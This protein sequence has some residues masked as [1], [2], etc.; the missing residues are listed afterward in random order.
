[1]KISLLAA[2]LAAAVATPCARA[3]ED[4]PETRDAAAT[5]LDAVSVI[6]AGQARQVQRIVPQQLDVLPPGT[7]L[8]KALNLLPGVNAQSADALGSN[9]QSMTMSLRGFNTTR[10]GYTLDGIPL[11]DGAYNNY[12][13]LSI[14]RALISENMGGAELAVGIGNLSTPS[15]SNLGGTVSY[16]SAD[17][18]TQFGGRFTQTFGS[19]GNRRSFLRVDS[20]E[21]GGFSGYVS[22]MDA[23][24]DL[25]NDQRAY[26]ASTT[27][28]FN[29]KGVYQDE[30][31]RLSAFVDTSRT[32]QADYF[33]LSKSEMARGL[34]WDWG[35]YAPDWDKAV[36]KAYCNASTYSAARCDRSDAALDAD[37]GFTGG[38]I[39]RD[40]NLY[41]LSADLFLS[42]A[43]TLHALGYRHSDD[44][45]GHNW[46]SG[47]WSNKGTAQE[48]PIIFRNTLYTID[49]NG[50][51]LGLDWDLGAHHLQAGAWL[52]HNTS[53]ASRY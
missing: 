19:D 49:R 35:G 10:L 38:Q 46:N 52:E 20:G 53:S 15:T 14:N 37:G 33:Y 22:A 40:D 31:V 28:Q 12:N 50:G 45:E 26:D 27:R 48:L 18:D 7:S 8:Q 4:M 44:G 29:A 42:D 6:G 34:G 9:E 5:T 32:S 51:T 39:L 13:G 24:S 23:R 16:F 30:H 47:A 2:A 1:M 3:A 41:S 11:G 36:A 17:P 25:W 43:L 21:H